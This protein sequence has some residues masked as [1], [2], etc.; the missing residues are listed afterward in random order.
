MSRLEQLSERYGEHHRT[1]RGR[2]FVF[3]GDERAQL[4]RQLVG[5]PGRRVLDLGCRY[6]TLTQ[7]YLQGN[8]VAGVDVD[9]EALAEAAKLGIETHWADLDEAF[10]FA[11][12]AFDV[13]V[14]GEVLEHVRDPEHIVTEA[15]RV[16]RPGGRF[17]GS[18]PNAYRLKNRLRFALG[19][20]PETDPTHLHMF[21]PGDVRALLSRFEHLELRLISS[22]FL[23]LHPRLLANDIVFAGTKPS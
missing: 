5:G 18:V 7:A 21:R 22:R 10:P 15:R 17:I 6:G 14:A 9:R 2:E 1:R 19:R 3:G 16:L 4:F 12:G 8:S 11:D 20:P 23:R 13:V